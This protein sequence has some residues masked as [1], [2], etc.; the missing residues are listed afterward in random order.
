MEGRFTDM[1]YLKIA[2]RNVLSNY[3]R[4][5]VTVLAIGIGLAAVNLFSGY[6]A[7]VYAGLKEQ[8]VKGE[9]L[10]HLTIYKQGMLTAGKLHPRKYM[11]TAAE[12]ARLTSIIRSDPRVRLVT[13]RVSVSGILSNGSAS[14]IF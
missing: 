10:G 2:W 9:R 8:A 4:S 5:L 3:R 7:N 12:S 11:F 1:N 13:P 14:T 6:I